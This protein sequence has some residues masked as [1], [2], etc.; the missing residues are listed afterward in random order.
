MKYELVD[1]DYLDLWMYFE[2]QAGNVKEAMFNSVTWVIGFA[3]AVFG[4]ILTVL[5]EFGSTN[6]SLKQPW[7]VVGASGV[8]VLLCAYSLILLNESKKH[9]LRNWGRAESCKSHVGSLQAIWEVSR[10]DTKRRW[11]PQVWHHIMMVVLAF[12]SG[13]FITLIWAICEI[14][15][16]CPAGGPHA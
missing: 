11:R 4:F 2:E 14:V 9:I 10:V 15:E 13:F 6:L 7:A 16:R 1:R 8:G 5:V 12:V 3:A